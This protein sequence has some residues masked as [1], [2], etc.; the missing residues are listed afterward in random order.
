MIDN[1][2]ISL[3]LVIVLPRK[4]KEPKVFALNL[5]NFRNAHHFIMN[6]AKKIMKD[7]I[8]AIAKDVIFPDPPYIFSYTIYPA[9]ARKFDLGNVAPGVQKF[10]DD[11]LVEL[12]KIKDDNYKIIKE[13]HYYFGGVDKENPRAELNIQTKR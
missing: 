7:I 1:V 10:T 4:T 13:V 6:N 5:N 8:E 12:G 11:A 9:S 3:P 2:I